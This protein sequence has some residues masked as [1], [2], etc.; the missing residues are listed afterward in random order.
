MAGGANVPFLP[1]MDP[2]VMPGA[3]FDAM[4]NQY[5]VRLLWMK[6]H[7]C[8][9]VY[10]GSMPGTPEIGCT[11]CHG[12]GVYWDAPVGPFQGLITYS[13]MVGAR[14]IDDPGATMDE[15]YGV[16]QRADPVLTLVAT[17]ASPNGVIWAAASMYDA[18]V[19]LDAITRFSTTLTVGGSAALPY[20]QSATVAA[21]GAVTIYDTATKS[22]V[23][24]PASGYTFSGGEVTL[25]GYPP[26]TAYTVEYTA[27][28]VYVAWKKAGSFPHVRPLGA[29]VPNLPKRF[30]LQLLDLWTR[31]RAAG[32]ASTS[33]QAI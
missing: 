27:A 15:T 12:R 13:Q 16:V 29:G 3:P 1:P 25:T 24:I 9:C 19:E 11:T 21:S 6:A 31:A 18:Y 7:D 14:S 10:G 32:S 26:D 30:Q 4:I 17:P 5:G 28:P 8:P 2:Y 33:P 20:Q 23:V 22:V